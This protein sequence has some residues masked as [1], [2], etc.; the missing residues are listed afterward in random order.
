MVI[1]NNKEWLNS[2]RNFYKSYIMRIIF[3]STLI[4]GACT[5]LFCFLV[6]E[7]FHVHM[8][9]SS[10]IF[11]WLGIVLSILLVF[12][13][14]TAYDRWW[15]G[16]KQWGSLVNNSR[17][18]A[19]GLHSLLDRHDRHH[20]SFFAKHISNF[21]FALVEHLRSGVK[22]HMLHHLET[23]EIQQYEKK[24]HIPN[25]IVA[26]IY[27]QTQNL[28]KEGIISGYDTIPVKAHIQALIDILGACE[29]I[30]K[31][32]IPFSYSIY[33]K[34]FVLAYSFML[35]FGLIAEFGYYTVPLVMLIFFAF[36]GIELMAEEIEDP[37]GLDCNDLPTGTIATTIKNNV[38]EI[39]LLPKE[40]EAEHI[41]E[42][43]KKVF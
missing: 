4:V 21:A 9:F 3:R 2:L 26:H 17:N 41:A 20:R 27:E 39:L 7:V 10:G 12:R 31:T 33:I 1:Y 29:R 5:A 25:Y 40:V 43:F 15:E 14:N 6:L 30:K 34:T 36:I 24:Q 38:C 23:H 22:I 32:P 37:F 28:Y 42:P 35:P 13:T 19:L 16:R 18:L 8:E 11:S